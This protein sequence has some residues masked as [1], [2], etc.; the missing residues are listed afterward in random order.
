MDFQLGPI[1][2]QLRPGDLQFV[3]RD[4]RFCKYFVLIWGDLVKYWINIYSAAIIKQFIIDCLLHLLKVEE[5]MDDLPPVV[6]RSTA[7][8]SSAEC[9][10]F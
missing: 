3:E 7:R 5:F 9:V 6:E 8:C 1:D 10:I 2:L 4:I